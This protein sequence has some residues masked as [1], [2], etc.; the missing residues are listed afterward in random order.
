MLTEVP[1][2]HRPDHHRAACLV[3]D[4]R[5]RV[6]LSRAH[7]ASVRPGL[8]WTVVPAGST[9]R[10]AAARVANRALGTRVPATQLHYLSELHL[11]PGPDGEAAHDLRVFAHQQ[12]GSA[13]RARTGPHLHWRP[14]ESIVEDELDPAAAHCLRKD[15]DR[16][17]SLTAEEIA[18]P[19]ALS[20]IEREA[21]RL[22]DPV[23][24]MWRKT[25]PAGVVVIGP[26]AVG[27]STLLKR[28]TAH[29]PHTDHVR[30]IVPVNRGPGRD[31]YLSRYLRGD[32]ASAFFCQMETLLLRVL[33]N[34]RTTGSGVLDQDVHSSLAY[35]KALRLSGALSRRQYETYYRYHHL[36]ASAL[37]PPAAVVHLTARTDV[38]MRRMRRRNR[39]LER[40]FTSSYVS[41]VAQCFEDVAEE[42]SARLPVHHIDASEM[43]PDQVLARFRELIPEHPVPTLTKEQQR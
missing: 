17:L 23:P 16:L 27:K 38:L 36:L 4:G 6:L 11:P 33:Q 31:N 1:P 42:L 25:E 18:E 24:G 39:V 15:L 35:A 20:D 8:P 26:P 30:D 32:D 7:S 19:A 3:L 34:L 14:L 5:G 22:I 43:T 29:A 9:A 12:R 37:L 21:R 13:P 28:H 40:S 2:R 41:L 10:Q